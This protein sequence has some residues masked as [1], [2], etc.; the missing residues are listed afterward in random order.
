[1]LSRNFLNLPCWN[2]PG[3]IAAMPLLDAHTV[4]A[5][6]LFA[7]III[8]HLSS[9]VIFIICSLS[10]AFITLKYKTWNPKELLFPG[11]LQ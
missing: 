11:A 5:Q 1:M 7:V 4:A 8:Y 10:M 9:L 3:I 2:Q 6:V